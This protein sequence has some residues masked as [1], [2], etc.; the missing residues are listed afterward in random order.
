VSVKI[1]ENAVMLG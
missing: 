1:T